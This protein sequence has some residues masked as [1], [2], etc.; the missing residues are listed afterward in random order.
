MSKQGRSGQ[1][2]SVRCATTNPIFAFGETPQNFRDRNL[3]IRRL[4]GLEENA[5]D[6]LCPELAFRFD[7]KNLASTRIKDLELCPVGP[8]KETVNAG[9]LGGRIVFDIEFCRW[10]SDAASASAP[11]SATI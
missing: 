9:I 3:F 7:L 1:T 4:G 2:L 5:A 6:R 10:Q 8:I 11:V